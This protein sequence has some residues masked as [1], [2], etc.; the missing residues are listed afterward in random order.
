MCVRLRG[1][2]YVSLF[3]ISTEVYNAMFVCVPVMHVCVLAEGV[4]S[5]ASGTWAVVQMKYKVP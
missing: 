1:H 5:T 3:V 4:W 2:V